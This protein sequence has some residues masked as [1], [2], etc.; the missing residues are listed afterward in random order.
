MGGVLRIF[1]RVDLCDGAHLL[2]VLY[3]SRELIE[4]IKT[5]GIM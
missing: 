3:G 2:E 1:Q 5:I 4:P